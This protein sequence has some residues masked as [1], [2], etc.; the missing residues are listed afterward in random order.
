MKNRDGVFHVSWF[1]RS[2]LSCFLHCLLKCPLISYILSEKYSVLEYS[3]GISSIFK[4]VRIGSLLLS[5][6]P[7]LSFRRKSQG[8]GQGI[9]VEN[10]FVRQPGENFQVENLIK[11]KLLPRN[12][13]KLAFWVETSV[14]NIDF[15]AAR[16]R[17]SG[18]ST[19]MGVG[20]KV[21][22]KTVWFFS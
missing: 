15:Q 3:L 12:H 11:S 19:Y 14:W 4:M 18:F 16:L 22:I 2:R 9:Y 20:G 17:L 8:G 7:L 1:F 13:R 5:S 21:K 6:G 10:N